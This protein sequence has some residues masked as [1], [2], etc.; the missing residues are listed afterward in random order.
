MTGVQ[1]CA[2]PIWLLGGA[3]TINAE[4]NNSSGVVSP[5]LSPGLLTVMGGNTFTQAVAGTLKI[6][7]GG[8]TAGTQYDQLAVSGIASLG[9]SLNVSLVNGFTPNPGDKFTILTCASRNGIFPVKNGA[10][11]N[12]GLVLLPLYSNTNVVLLATNLTV[13]QPSLSFAQNGNNLQLSWS[14]L[15]GQP[16]QIEY[17]GDLQQWF[18]LSNLVATAVNSSVIDQ[19][20]IPGVPKRFYRLR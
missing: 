13:L 8:L 7:L 9:G 20:P 19:T 1:T 5:G 6:E 12:N 17:S 14:S 10:L 11:L 16:Y 3:G 18:V 15:I 2:L 4:V